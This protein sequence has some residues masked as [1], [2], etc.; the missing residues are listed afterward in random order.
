MPNA[1]LPVCSGAGIGACCRQRR[2]VG[3]QREVKFLRLASWGA[4]DRAVRMHPPT[5]GIRIDDPDTEEMTLDLPAGSAR[6]LICYS[7]FDEATFDLPA[8]GREMTISVQYQFL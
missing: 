1:S 3:P 4:C 8:E 5:P 7:T 2:P 6:S